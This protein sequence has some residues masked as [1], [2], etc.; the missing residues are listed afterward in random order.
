MNEQ[1]LNIPWMIDDQDKENL[2]LLVSAP[3]GTVFDVPIHKRAVE[4][5]PGLLANNGL[6]RTFFSSL[7]RSIPIV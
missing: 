7:I 2:L 4:E 5:L 1:A 6:W 3:D